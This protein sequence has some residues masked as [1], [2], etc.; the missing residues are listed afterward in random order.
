MDRRQTFQ[1]T[2][3]T[4]RGFLN[5]VVIVGAGVATGSGVN[6]IGNGHAD[7]AG[8]LT[9]DVATIANVT[10]TVETLAVT[11]Y[12][13]AI[14]AATFHIDEA[15]VACLA[16]MMDAEM[17]HLHMLRSLGG[18]AQHHHFYLPDHLLADA[19]VFVHTG[20][21]VEKTCAGMYLAATRQLA[22]LGQPQLAA[23][24]AQHAARH[25]QHLTLIGHIAGLPVH[26]LTMPAPAFSQ[27]S[28]AVRTL[29]PFLA[30]G[31][32]FNGPIRFPSAQRYQAARA[33]STAEHLQPAATQ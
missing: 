8:T 7:A 26:D 2:R 11:F 3:S 1:K 6:M 21:T 17:Q 31:S 20:L 12:Y 9:D 13:T 24:A 23:T 15:S 19:R 14:T 16:A 10:T 28:G 29:G 32:G 27:V 30:G 18:V 33:A 4:R 5:K 25:A 22:A